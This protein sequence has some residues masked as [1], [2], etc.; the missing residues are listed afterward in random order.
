M[1]KNNEQII[2]DGVNVTQCGFFSKVEGKQTN[3]C[4]IRLCHELETEKF[5]GYLECST[6]HN[7]HYKQLQR[8]EQE[9][10]ELK[11]ELKSTKGLVTVGNKQLAEALKGYD[12][13]KKENEKL[14]QEL[15]GQE[16]IINRLIKQVDNQKQ[17]L[18]EIREIACDGYNNGQTSYAT[19]QCEKIINIINEVQNVENN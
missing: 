18:E 8:K 17:T 12:Q 9:C 4:Y 5:I 19:L 1:T 16:K 15:Y 11:K 13:L 6:S 2:I 10:E 3:V 7:C 14:T